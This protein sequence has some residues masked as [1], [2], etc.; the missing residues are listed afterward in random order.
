M[1][2]L[3]RFALQTLGGDRMDVI[4]ERMA[5]HRRLMASTPPAPRIGGRPAAPGGDEAGSGGDD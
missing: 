5:A 4:R 1:L 2:T 3:A